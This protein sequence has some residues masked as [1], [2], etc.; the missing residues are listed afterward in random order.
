MVGAV[1]PPAEY[2]PGVP[3]SRTGA[4]SLLDWAA[5]CRISVSQVVVFD[6]E[7]VIGCRMMM[8]MMNSL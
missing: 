8:M 7:L 4:P 2:V 5:I 6:R 1:G 3:C